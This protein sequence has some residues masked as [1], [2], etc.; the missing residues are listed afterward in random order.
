MSAAHFYKLEQII[1]AGPGPGQDGVVRWRAIDVKWVIEEKFGVCYSECHVRKLLNKLG[2]SRI[3]TRPQ[4]P[5]QV[6]SVIAALK[7]YPITLKAH[8]AELP[9]KKR[10]EV[11]WQDE[12]RIGQKNGHTRNLGPQRHTAPPAC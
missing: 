3:S 5:R 4:H 11:W 1:E 10:I 9:E 12:A 2:F 6:A 7:N 8:L